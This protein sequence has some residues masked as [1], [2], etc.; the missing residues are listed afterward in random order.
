M[1][2]RAKCKILAMKNRKE[3]CHLPWSTYAFD[4]AQSF[5]SLTKLMVLHL[6]NGQQIFNTSEKYGIPKDIRSHLPK[7]FICEYRTKS[8]SKWVTG[9]SNSFKTLFTWLNVKTNGR[10]NCKWN[11][12]SARALGSTPRANTCLDPPKSSSSTVVACLLL[13]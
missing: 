10:C 4:K 1:Y 6:P 11:F 3:L 13:C 7:G 2:Y 9:N 5:T 12:L 8:S